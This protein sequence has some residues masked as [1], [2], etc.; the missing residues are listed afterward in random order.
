[1]KQLLVA[2]LLAALVA[3]G[4][5]SRPSPANAGDPPAGAATKAAPAVEADCASYE[6]QVELCQP[7]CEACAESTPGNA[8]NVCAEGCADRIYCEQCQATDHCPG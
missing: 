7:T 5:S 8:C 6:H 2:S 4:S 1:M 3:C